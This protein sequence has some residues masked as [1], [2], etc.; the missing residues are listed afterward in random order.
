MAS[1]Q[2]P[3]N[4]QRPGGAA[5]FPALPGG[6]FLSCSGLREAGFQASLLVGGAFL[7]LAKL[8]PF[9]PPPAN[10]GEL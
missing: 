1:V 9:S 7:P 10:P 8:Q 6:F 3:G 5:G 4:R 2:G